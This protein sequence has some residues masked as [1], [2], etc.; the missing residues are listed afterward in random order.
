M[1]L[2][3]FTTTLL[4]PLEQIEAAQAALYEAQTW[5]LENSAPL[6]ILANQNTASNHLSNHHLGPSPPVFCHQTYSTKHAINSISFPRFNS[7]PQWQLTSTAMSLI[8]G[9]R[10]SPLQDDKEEFFDENPQAKQSDGWQDV[11]LIPSSTNSEI[12]SGA[13]SASPKPRRS[14]KDKRD[15]AGEKAKKKKTSLKVRCI[16]KSTPPILSG[17]AWCAK[18]VEWLQPSRALTSLQ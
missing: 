4:T 8:T 7:N 3:Q 5:L 14:K 10:F 11:I 18:E 13:T 6:C 1:D 9:N 15:K 12:V 16:P 17:P 2:R